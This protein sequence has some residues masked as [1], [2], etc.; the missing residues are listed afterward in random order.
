MQPGYLCLEI[1]LLFSD[2]VLNLNTLQALVEACSEVQRDSK[3]NS[4]FII[5]TS[6]DQDPSQQKMSLHFELE[7]YERM[8]V[9]Y[10]QAIA[11]PSLK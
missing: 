1:P 6:R 10:V 5:P 4:G 11:A 7:E 3:V 9:A 2:T 8:F